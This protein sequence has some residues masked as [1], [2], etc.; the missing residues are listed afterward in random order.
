M[1]PN[2]HDSH[3]TINQLMIKI[4]DDKL[5]VDVNMHREPIAIPSVRFRKFE[6]EEMAK[7]HSDTETL[8]SIARAKYNLDYKLLKEVIKFRNIMCMYGQYPATLKVFLLDLSPYV[9]MVVLSSQQG[10]GST[11]ICAIRIKDILKCIKRKSKDSDGYLF[12]DKITRRTI[13]STSW[14]L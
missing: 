3:V 9:D 14:G 2:I 12:F 8:T 10:F 1:L 6:S 5:L 4:P 13:E 11:G 7:A